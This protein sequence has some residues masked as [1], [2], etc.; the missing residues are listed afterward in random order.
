MRV[1]VDV[2]QEQLA[3][4]ADLAKKRK[5]PRAE[6]IRQAL[7]TYVVTNR[8]PLASY[9]GLWANKGKLDNPETSDPEAYVAKLRS[10]WER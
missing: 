7:E 1:L 4:L 10:E 5:L 3:A 9:V 8:A 2:S 6:I